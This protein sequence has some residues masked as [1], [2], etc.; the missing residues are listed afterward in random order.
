MEA[1]QS[2]VDT[3]CYHCGDPC[4]AETITADDKDFCCQG[5]KTVYEILNENELCDYYDLGANPGVSRKEEGEQSVFDFLD[6]AAIK[7]DLLEFASAEHEKVTFQVPAIHCS[8]CIWLLENLE[9]LSTAVISSQVNFTQKQATIHYNPQEISLREVAELLDKIGYAPLINLDSERQQDT[10]KNTYSK[11]L[12]LKMGIAGFCF[13]NIMLLSFPD[14]LGLTGIEQSYQS[15]FRYLNALLAIPVVFYAGAEYFVSA[16]KSLRQRFANIDVPIA[17]GISVL[18]LRSSYEVLANT[19]A[20]YFDSLAGLVFFLLIGKW[21]QNKTYRSLA[22]DR[23]YKSYF[24][25]AVLRKEGAELVPTQV[26]ELKKG[27][28]VHMRNGEV[29]PADAVLIDESAAIDYSFITGESEPVYQQKGDYLYAGGRHTGP[30]TRLIVQKAVSQSYLTRLWN[31]E[32][33]QEES[34]SRSLVDR[35]SQY[36]T[37]VIISIAVLAAIFWQVTNPANTWLVFTAVLIVACPCALALVTPFTTGSV[38]RVFGRNRFYLKN[39]A[40][41][42]RISDI[43][44]LVFDKTGT[45]TRTNAQSLDFVGD[46]LS[47]SEQDLLRPVVASSTH[48]L[49]RLIL[50]ALAEDKDL[51]VEHFEEITGKGVEAR[52]AGVAIKLGSASFV[53]SDAEKEVAATR[54]YVQINGV[55]RGYFK[56]RSEYRPGIGEAIHELSPD[57]KMA[58]LSGDNSSEELALRQFFPMGALMKFEQ[59]PESKMTTIRQMQADGRQVAMLGDGLNDAGALKQSEMGIAV[60]QDVS[61]FSPASDAILE[62]ASISKLHQLLNLGKRSKRVIKASF[63]LSFLYNVVGITLAVIGVFTPLI[64]AVLMP[65]SSISIVIF[66]TAGVHMYARKLKLN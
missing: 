5:C 66:T 39:A 9:R 47:A 29:I 48:P 27:D 37:I 11:R 1:V 17:L 20:G 3:S 24:P 42:E 21:F 31:D 60:S 15:F 59:S 56:V 22:F 34:Q 63:V 58:V 52:V 13:G 44:T 38:M 28:E 7:A 36:F 23:D 64:A 8:S 18:F 26:S 41:V 62:A 2:Q 55:V 4:E 57:Y 45:I 16:F 12:L 32:A 33:F 61:N 6:N 51:T 14:Y 50:A 65:L 25:L 54:V 19:G 40:V 49:S 10:Q 46:A 43:D 35:I 53:G 30:M